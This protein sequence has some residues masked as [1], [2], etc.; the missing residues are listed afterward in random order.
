MR[1]L[2][3]S[4]ILAGILLCR[5]G[6]LA[7]VQNEIPDPRED[8]QTQVVLAL[9]RTAIAA[10]DSMDLSLS[11]SGLSG[12][13]IYSLYLK[14]A[15]DTTVVRILDVQKTGVT[16]DWQNP[17]W[18]VVN[19]EL[20]ISHFGTT[21]FTGNGEALLIRILAIGEEDEST[22]LDFNLAALNEGDP[23]CATIHGIVYI[24][25]PSPWFDQ[26]GDLQYNEN[27]LISLEV[28]AH[29]PLELHLTLS[30]QDLPSNAL[31]ED[32]GGGAGL[33]SWAPDYYSAGFYNL[34]FQATNTAEL[35]GELSL[36][37]EIVNVPQ[38]P[39]IHTPIEDVTFNEDSQCQAFLLSDHVSDS[40]LDQGDVL[41]V[42]LSGNSHVTA[43]LS[44]GYVVFTA[45]PDWFGVENVNLLITDS[46]ELQTSQQI[47]VTVL[48]VNDPPV[49]VS[50]LPVIT[51]TEDHPGVELDLGTYFADV[52]N[53][54]NFS[55]SGAENLVCN[56]SGPVLTVIPHADWFGSETVL[57]TATE[58]SLIQPG[59]LALV[60]GLRERLGVSADL[61]VIVTPVNDPPVIVQPFPQINMYYNETYV[62]NDLDAYILDVD[63]PLSFNFSGNENISIGQAGN[64]L[65]ITPDPDWIGVRRI[66]VSATDDHMESVSQVLE[67]VVR[68]SYL[69]E[70]DFDHGGSLPAG[71]T[72][73]GGY[74]MPYPESGSDYAMRV[75]NPQLSTTQRLVT[76]SINLSTIKN[77]VVSFWQELVCPAGVTATL[78]YSLNGITY[79][80]F[81]NFSQST[82]GWYSVAFPQIE[83]Q[84]NVRIRWHYLSTTA[85]TNYWLI[86]NF[87]I[88]G[89]VGDYVVPPQV[90]D[91]TVTD[92]GFD[93][94]TLA[95]TTVNDQFFD[96]YEICV[97]SD[98]LLT[99]QLFVWSSDD[100]PGLN[101]QSTGNTTITGLQYLTK[102]YFAIR[103]KDLSDNRSPWS[104]IIPGCVSPP[105]SI[106]IITSYGVWFDSHDFVIECQITDDV[107]VNASSISYR[108]DLNNDGLYGPDDVWNPVN[109]YS[110]GSSLNVQIPLSYP[111]DGTLVHYEIRCADT[112]NPILIY[113]GSLSQEGIE[114]D[115]HVN[116]DTVLPD[117]ILDLS[118]LS[119]T[120]C[121]VQLGWEASADASFS[122]YE[123][124]YSQQQEVDTDDILFSTDQ[125]PLL[126]VISTTSTNITGLLS[127]TRYWFR[128]LA[129]DLAGNKGGLS[130]TVT[131]VLNSV[132]P[133]IFD[134]VPVQDTI[135]RFTNSLNTT[136]GCKIND[137]YGVDLSTV[138]YRIDS[139]GNGVY[140]A[141]EIWKNAFGNG[142][143][144]PAGKD[145]GMRELKETQDEE[146]S[147]NI[148]VTFTIESD[149]LR[150][151]FRAKDIDGY[152][153][154]Y[155]GFD[156]MAGID[157]DWYVSIDATP[158]SEIEAITLGMVTISSAEI[159]W[160]CSSDL[161]FVGYRLYY[162]NAPGVTME[163]ANYSFEEYDELVDP[164]EVTKMFTMENLQPSTQYYVRVAAFDIAG[165]YTLSDE[166]G[167]FTSS[168]I[169]PM[170]PQNMILSVSDQDLTLSWTP[171]TQDINGNPITVNQYMIYLS[172]T[173]Y[174]PLD[175]STYFD[176][177]DSSSFVLEG[178]VEFIDRLF[179]RVVA[180]Y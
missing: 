97:M 88:S 83:N 139:N 155:S 22:L 148:N 52:D 80:N 40:D 43:H 144:T 46:Y 132:A 162:S 125:E 96:C 138:Q 104:T 175:E 180:V 178:V 10:G 16:Q 70:E 36:Q 113:S 151:E 55:V 105:P 41:N 176:T 91:L 37:I 121:S 109:G 72:R 128:I 152:G 54:L 169:V 15:V 159:A 156:N 168:D 7:G 136:I 57:L 166:I 165:N 5:P 108:I 110:D 1:Y 25:I 93:S 90:Q 179:F 34:L 102:Y 45:S 135:L 154:S 8:P 79:T 133:F 61:T 171:V 145:E 18:N 134:P 84:A 177:V 17:T 67:V 68:A 56:I 107:L 60:D 157:D 26:I 63:S 129:V 73:T 160:T 78:Q 27:E 53:E 81:E 82:S 119:V 126:G 2:A 64:S 85:V 66:L 30:V 11:V 101:D 33:L 174:F 4:L 173:P 51:I 94:I 12:Q 147:V 58:G 158:P 99:S 172:D 95:W 124:Y 31:F 143:K 140:D 65:E 59:K 13:E 44:E 153:Y 122:H 62:L 50:A 100:D 103:A 28:L 71:W 14:V 118:T 35:A 142:A 42:T 150:F 23:A 146:I 131:N 69:Y 47:T 130:N 86:D 6:P 170:Q 24:G 20:R 167:F 3:I 111:Q 117:A 77:P 164:G 116:I 114:D 32:L 112:Q 87:S 106:E 21:P 89:V 149:T 92:A 161:H 141:E 115:H 163:A 38:P 74:W 123:I 75:A 137:A 127:N 49:L 39:V 120:D 9:P 48:N 29:D 19:G 98:S 76:P